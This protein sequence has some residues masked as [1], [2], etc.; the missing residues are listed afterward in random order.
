MNKIFR[1][2]LKN[3]TQGDEEKE[4]WLWDLFYN[5]EVSIGIAIAFA[6]CIIAF[7]V[8]GLFAGMNVGFS[9]IFDLKWLL[10]ATGV[11]LL[12]GLF[13]A[14]AIVSPL[15]E[16]DGEKQ[17]RKEKVKQGSLFLATAIGH[18]ANFIVN[19]GP[20]LFLIVCIMSFNWILILGSCVGV[21]LYYLIL[22]L[23][24][25]NA[26]D[27]VKWRFNWAIE[28][29][30]MLFSGH[31]KWWTS[32]ADMSVQ[33]FNLKKFQ[34][35][36]YHA[37]LSLIMIP[38][39][40]TIFML[41]TAT[42]GKDAAKRTDKIQVTTDSITT[43][44]VVENNAISEPEEVIENQ[45][46]EQSAIIS[47]NED[48]YSESSTSTGDE[49]SIQTVVVTGVNVRLR[50]SPEINDYNIIKDASGK[51]LHPNKGEQLQCIGEDGDFYL[52]NFRGNNV[53][54]SKQFAVIQ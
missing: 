17:V 36:K 53:Y 49:N 48:T 10:M 1:R 4:L 15:N 46:N 31:Y 30:E 40:G 52:V 19:W 54:I 27:Y 29:Y 18:V 44:D 20:L 13:V 11:P 34:N 6:L 7:L 12:F 22:G 51:N 16:S 25:S 26:K 43:P 2:F 41:S 50:T 24:K 39:M 21:I 45:E 38:L 37:T 32:A 8:I 14:G 28:N 47:E 5:Y 33:K 3:R 23:V 35:Y 9:K 42:I